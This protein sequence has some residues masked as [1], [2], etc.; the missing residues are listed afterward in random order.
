MMLQR[1]HLG[2]IVWITS[3]HCLGYLWWSITAKQKEN[4]RKKEQKFF[5][6]I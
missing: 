3:L 6:A 1:L 5:L 4:E 2:Y